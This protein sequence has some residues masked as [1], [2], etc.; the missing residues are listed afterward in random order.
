M[1]KALFHHRRGSVSEFRLCGAPGV[2]ARVGDPGSAWPCPR[3]SCP[4]VSTACRRPGRRL[5][6]P[7]L[8]ARLGAASPRALP[9]APP[10]APGIPA[11]QHVRR[12]PPR[13]PA[14]E[15][16]PRA[17]PE[18]WFPEPVRAAGAR[19]GQGTR[20]RPSTTAACGRRVGGA[21]P[22]PSGCGRGAETEILGT[23]RISELRETVGLAAF[24]LTP[25]T[26]IGGEQRKCY[27]ELGTRDRTPCFVNVRQALSH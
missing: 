16:P 11:R 26:G 3:R 20:A 21:A 23:Q 12:P 8:P 13:E 24:F 10:P 4:P 6:E 22:E 14:G 1:G 9:G 25:A 27:R 19:D 18:G 15:A 5:P 7:S 17:G 2:T